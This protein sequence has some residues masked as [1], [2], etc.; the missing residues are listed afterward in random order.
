MGKPYELNASRIM[1]QNVTLEVRVT[2]LALAKLRLQLALPFIWLAAKI[3]GVGL[4]VN[5]E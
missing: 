1:S 3:A 5:V 4:S 2:G